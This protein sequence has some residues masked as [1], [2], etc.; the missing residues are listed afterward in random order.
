LKERDLG[1]FFSIY[2]M[3]FGFKEMSSNYSIW[4]IDEVNRTTMPLKLVNHIK[5]TPNI[6]IHNNLIVLKFHQN[7]IFEEIENNVSLVHQNFYINGE[8]L[9]ENQVLKAGT[10]SI[11]KRYKL[12]RDI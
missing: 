6:I 3:K 12:S 2:S 9:D 11:Q 7:T 1:K 8:R 10:H 5:C 4:G